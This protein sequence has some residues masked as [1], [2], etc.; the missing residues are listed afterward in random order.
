MDAGPPLGDDLLMRTRA[1]VVREVG[2]PIR[3]E[4]LELEEP[5]AGEVLISVQA[6]G[7]CHSDWHLVTGATKHPLPVVLGHEGA[8]V[9]EA[10]GDGV[11]SV[12]AGDPI[13]LNWAPY[14][15]TCTL[16]SKGSPALCREFI[17]P[18]WD[19]VMLDGTP[20]LRTLEGDP[21]YHYSGLACFA[22]RAVVPES[23]CVKVAPDVPAEVAALVGCAVTTGVGAVFNTAG[24][25]AGESVAVLG[26]GG[27]GLSAVLGAKAA[28]ADPIMVVDPAADRRAKALEIGATLAIE[29]GGALDAV[30]AAT[31]GLG[32]DWTFECVGAADV[33][34]AALECARPGGKCVLVGLAAMG[35]GFELDTAALVRQEKSVIGSYYGSCDPARDLIGYVNRWAAGELAVDALVTRRWRLDQVAEA[36]DALLAGEGARAVIVME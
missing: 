20:R 11:D 22:E 6:A 24:V 29:P 34:R 36:Y 9:V 26:A 8:G 28:G 10:V 16:C 15:G 31:D 5:R 23:C 32:A 18:L 30:R 33:Q 7:V 13:A 27:V 25:K 19:G 17:G 1:A 2:G 14:C 4:E 21:V 3:V 12:G 35:T